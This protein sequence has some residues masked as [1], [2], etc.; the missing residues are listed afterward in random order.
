MRVLLPSPAE[1]RIESPVPLPLPAPGPGTRG[2]LELMLGVVLPTAALVIEMATGMSADAYANPLPNW[3]ALILAWMVPVANLV[4]WLGPQF[5]PARWR[6]YLSGLA[7]VMASIFGILYMPLAPFAILAILAVGIGLLPLSPF[8][9]VFTALR[10]LRDVTNEPGAPS[11][12]RALSLAIAIVITAAAPSVW[13]HWLLDRAIHG[14]PAER[15]RAVSWLRTIGDRGEL[16][17]SADR[18]RSAGWLGRYGNPAEA[19]KVY[20]LVTG[21]AHED[22]PRNRRGWL[23]IDFDW[24]EEQGQ[25]RVGRLLKGLSVSSSRIEGR[26]TPR[27]GI[28]YQEWTLEF[29]N[30]ANLQ[31][32]ARAVIALPQDGVVSRVT[33]WIDGEEREAA[34]GGRAQTKAAYQSVVSVRRDPLLVESAGPGRVLAQCFPIPA[35]GSMKIRLGISAPV[36]DGQVQLPYFVDRNFSVDGVHH[37]VWIDGGADPFSRGLADAAMTAPLAI[38]VADPAEVVWTPHPL[39]KSRVIVQRAAT[40]QP[41]PDRLTVVVDG[42]KS[43]AALAEPIRTS[44]ARAAKQHPNWRLIETGD[45]RG[46]SDNIAALQG[47]QD[48]LASM[49]GG[50]ILWLHGPQPVEVTSAEV[51]RGHLERKKSRIELVTAQLVPGPDTVTPKLDGIATVRALRATASDWPDRL[52]EAGGFVR[53]AIPA[54]GKPEGFEAPMDL[55]R[56]WASAEIPRLLPRDA[57]AATQLGAGLRMVTPASGA[58]VLENQSQYQAFGLDPDKGL[59]NV[60]EPGTIILVGGGLVVL[61]VLQRRKKRNAIS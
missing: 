4:G 1:P 47:A 25:D 44:L 53:E 26:I 20:Y 14:D 9:A 45:Y 50:T 5:S 39:D 43:M 3:R 61:C 7:V 31:R 8:G 32:E 23:D 29:R 33:L 12:L 60:P 48:Q 22:T 30:T 35:R 58:V 11:A 57:K 10:Q 38:H 56:L 46:G 2:V 15:A 21:E 37:S 41:L 55:A 17:E 13:T 36:R 18:F 54:A 19:R 51:L 28:H 16:R 52:A 49:G 40:G 34:F 24:D 42:S 59:T 27:A 6:G